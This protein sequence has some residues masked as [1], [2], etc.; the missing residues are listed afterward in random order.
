MTRIFI[1]PSKY[2]QGSGA[3]GEIGK[4]ASPLGKKAL[5]TGGKRALAAVQDA[6]ESSLGKI[7]RGFWAKSKAYMFGDGGQKLEVKGH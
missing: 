4:Y 1:A 7:F 2:I 6:I 5:V 3:I